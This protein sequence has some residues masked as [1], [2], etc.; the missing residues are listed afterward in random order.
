MR[1]KYLPQVKLDN[2]NHNKTF[3][4]TK[5]TDFNL[6]NEIWCKIFSYLP[7]APKK[8]A[9]ATCKLW[10]RLIREDPKLSGYILISWYNMKTAQ[11]TL[12][13]NWSSWSALKTLELN[14]LELVTDS[15]DSIQNVIEKLSLKDH[16]PS[17]EEVLFDVGLTPEIHTPS[18]SLLKYQPH[19]GQIYGFGQNLDSSQ[20]WSKYEL[21]MKALRKL[22]SMGYRASGTM[23][24]VG[25]LPFAELRGR[26]VG[27][28]IFAGL[29]AALSNDPLLL[30]DNIYFHF[31]CHT[32]DLIT[33]CDVEYARLKDFFGICPV[34]GDEFKRILLE[35]VGTT[36]AK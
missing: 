19:T 28:R 15:R 25:Q 14:K 20:Q 16:C 3:L 27:A 34:S 18:Q 31:F 13:W 35:L 8:N 10:S 22:K 6:P 17:L 30:N 36:P 26:T 24:A 2:K 21:N 29:E 9:T 4:T 23:G 5:M 33:E 12:Q 11:E 32:L 7:L 1:G